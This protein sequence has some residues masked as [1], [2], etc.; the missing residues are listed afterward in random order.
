[1]W[2][3]Y[4]KHQQSYVSFLTRQANFGNYTESNNNSQKNVNNWKNN[5]GRLTLIANKTYSMIMWHVHKE[6]NQSRCKEIKWKLYNCKM[7]LLKLRTQ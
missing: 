7:H 2:S 3:Q 1:M 4:L 5:E 6:T